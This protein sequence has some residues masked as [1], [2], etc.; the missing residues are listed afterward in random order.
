LR[1]F[2]ERGARA[3]LVLIDEFARTTTPREGRALLVALL[4]RLR[5]GG[6]RALAATHLHGV[7]REAGVAHYTIAGLRELPPRPRVPLDL[8][9]ALNLIGAAMDYRLLP[10]DEDEAVAGDALTL[11]DALGLD[12]ALVARARAELNGPG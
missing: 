1:D 9:A 2:F 6:A 7:A 11:A 4:E 10:G 3:P 12:A 8:A 5:G